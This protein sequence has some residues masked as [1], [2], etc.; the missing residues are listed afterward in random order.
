MRALVVSAAGPAVA[1]VPEPP[2]R[3]GALLAATVALGVCGTDREIAARGP[4]AMP[5]GRDRIVLGHES[6]GRVIEAPPGSGFAPGDLIAGLV[7]RPDP[8]PCGFCAAGRPDLCE[9]GRFTERGITG[10]DGFG[11]ERF[12]VEPEYAVRVDPG[13]AGVL[14]EPA[15]VAVKAW[16]QLDRVAGRPAARALVLGAGPIGLLC[17][18]LAARRGLEVHVVDRIGRGPKPERA[19]AL[20]AAYHTSTDGLGSGFDRVLECT[21]HLVAEAIAHTAPSGATCLVGGGDPATAPPVTLGALSEDIL[22]NNKA[23]VGTVNSARRHFEAAREALRAADREWLAGLLTRTV[24]LAEWRTALDP[25][26]E[27]IK[28]VLDFGG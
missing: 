24:T 21:G 10:R 5:P 25:P 28:T 26:P 11:A 13:P 19:R 15:S 6:L 8:V 12:R 22:A 16:E 3:D 17:A 23:I 1:E 2:L 27:E 9:N 14:V 7:R 20:G 18:L 4:A